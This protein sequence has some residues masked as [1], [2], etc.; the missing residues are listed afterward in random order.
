MKE[1]ANFDLAT[2]EGQ[3]LQDQLT[4][5]ADAA[6][7]LSTSL[8][9]QGKFDEANQVMANYALGLI[10]V[11][12]NAGWSQDQIA[13]MIATMGLT[14][15]VIQTLINLP[16][17]DQAII[18][19]LQT[20]GLLTGIDGYTANATVHI[21]VVVDQNDPS[22]VRNAMEG[23]GAF[24]P[25]FDAAAFAQQFMNGVLSNIPSGS[26]SGGGGGGGGGGAAKW[27][28][29]AQQQKNMKAALAKPLINLLTG[30]L[31]AAWQKQMVDQW[32]FQATKN[33]L[34]E[35]K[36]RVGAGIL[37][38]AQKSGQDPSDEF[39][40][41]TMAYD[42][43]VKVAGK[44]NADL[45]LDQFESLEAFEDYV[46]RIEEL[47]E[48]QREVEDWRHEWELI[49][50]EEYRKILKDRLALT[51][52]FSQEWMAIMNEIK[53]LDED[54]TAE[55][56]RLAAA[57]HETEAT[58]TSEYLNYLYTRLNAYEQYSQEWMDIWREIQ[59]LEQG[60]IDKQKDKEDAIKDFADAVKDAFDD[61]K[62]SVE[63]PI[64]QAT[65]LVQAFGDQ[66]TMSMEQLRGFYQHQ[67]EGVQRWVT[68][69]KELKNRGINAKFLNE[70]ISAG[71][72]SLGFAESVLNLG[73]EGISFINQS[74]A[75]IA[76]MAGD[77][78]TNIATG[79]VGTLVQ[80]DNSMTIT[81]GD[82]QITGE[83]EG[84][85]IAE[86][87]AAIDAALGQV[88]QDVR[89][90]QPTNYAQQRREMA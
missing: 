89:S 77:L 28:P 26:G 42:R 50:Y 69:I 71:P 2:E 20:A 30:D 43:L 38:A 88:A 8:Y 32:Y 7:A 12:E 25:G 61:I 74:M 62:R 1:G 84:V 52:E 60:E 29:S 70:L 58:T 90:H 80:N 85:T 82:I 59:D 66:A 21:G 68:V 19:L 9:D 13:W 4:S 44:A 40:S 22:S 56:D 83:M 37:T 24:A 36:T 10:A 33:I 75:D 78:G 57:K 73:D 79:N 49:G 34:S 11:A 53:S 48:H 5:T 81:V 23:R 55:Q 76:S 31:G 63:D 51:E 67:M 64:L 18:N 47:V 16:G 35:G 87:Q 39:D 46:N 15:E 41:L 45:A 3:A 54:F 17:I 65:S 6:I 72:Q 27:K 86:V 14:P